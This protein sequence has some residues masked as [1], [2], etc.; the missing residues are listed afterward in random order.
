MRLVLV[1]APNCHGCEL[2]KRYL[3]SKGV[4]FETLDVS[5]FDALK[6]FRER[7]G[8]SIM[9]VPMLFWV[10]DSRIV[11]GLSGWRGPRATDEFLALGKEGEP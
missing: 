10:E 1:T 3:L 4:E 6:R 8:A 9:S 5:N 2:L 11:Y 7:Y